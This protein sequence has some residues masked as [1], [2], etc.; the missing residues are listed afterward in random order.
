MNADEAVSRGAALQ[1]AIL[2][3][4]FKVLPYEIVEAQ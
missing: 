3:P 1:S 4:R 2:S